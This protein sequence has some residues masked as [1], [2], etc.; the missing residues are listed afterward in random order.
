MRGNFPARGGVAEKLLQR[1]VPARPANQP[2]MQPQQHHP[3]ILLFIV[4]VKLVEVAAGIVKPAFRRHGG[5]GL[6]ATS[7]ELDWR[8]FSDPG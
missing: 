4:T 3:G 1:P 7:A 2:Q 5:F 6:I 8:I